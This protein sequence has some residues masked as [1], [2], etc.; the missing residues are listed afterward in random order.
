MPV[1]LF[2]MY[3]ALLAAM[4]WAGAGVAQAADT[5]FVVASSDNAPR[6]FAL[7]PARD[8]VVRAK[9]AEGPTVLRSDRQ[10][11]R[12]GFL[13]IDRAGA[14]ALPLTHA[15][16]T[17]VSPA[18]VTAPGHVVVVR[19][20]ATEAAK[21][22]S[23]A[24]EED[25][26]ITDLFAAAPAT[27]DFRQALAGYAAGGSVQ[28]AWPLPAN[29]RQELT[30]GYGMRADPFDGHPAF[31]GGIDVAALPGTPVLATADG[32]VSRV[33][34]AGGLGNFVAVQHRDGTESYYGHLRAQSVRIGQRIMQGQKL[35]ELGSTGRSTGPHL[36]YRIRR[37]G[38]QFNP[39]LVLH[40]PNTVVASR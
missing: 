32:V 12:D 14:R 4:L 9:P 28:H 29:I 19:P 24:T 33:E 37:N 22:A 7:K 34:T 2:R 21:P 36:D 13:R 40:A 26:E 30:S 20:A 27:T 1:A 15:T 35:G 25:S 5:A 39:M 23:I 10:A 31:H 38:E 8:G 3:P 16:I 11:A 6:Y 17:R 18:R